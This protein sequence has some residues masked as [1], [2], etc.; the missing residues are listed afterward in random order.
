MLP[1]AVALK[2]VPAPVIR[3]RAFGLAPEPRRGRPL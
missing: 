2:E 3:R 1:F